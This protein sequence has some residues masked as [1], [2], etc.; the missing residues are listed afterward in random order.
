MEDW[1]GGGLATVKRGY[2]TGLAKVASQ[3]DFKDTAM[4]GTVWNRCAWLSCES[5]DWNKDKRHSLRFEVH[6]C[7]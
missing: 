2:W 6:G 4:T 1:R 5:S 7:I 3:D